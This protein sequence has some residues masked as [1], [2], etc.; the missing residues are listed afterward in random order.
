M[1]IWTFLYK[2]LCRPIFISLECIYGHGISESYRVT[3][4]VSCQT[5]FQ[6]SRTILHSHKRCMRVLISPHPC[7]HLLLSIFLI[8]TILIRVKWYVTV[9]LICI[10]S[11]AN[12]VEHYV[13]CFLAICAFP[14][15]KYLF[16]AF[17]H[18][19]IGLFFSKLYLG[20]TV[21]HHA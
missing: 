13:K 2:F 14:L 12:G 15:G 5:V 9:I 3:P 10:S 4:C 8:I 17:T 1:L 7:Q 6:S 11:M 16:R 18:F 21:F 19:L 20:P